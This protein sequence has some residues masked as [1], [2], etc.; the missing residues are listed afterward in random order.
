ME[1]TAVASPQS[2]HHH[3]GRDERRV[4]IRIASYHWIILEPTT[5]VIHLLLF[6]RVANSLH[7]IFRLRSTESFYLYSKT[8]YNFR[9]NG[10]WVNFWQ[11]KSQW[12]CLFSLNHDGSIGRLTSRGCRWRAYVM[13]IKY[14]STHPERVRLAKSIFKMALCCC[15]WFCLPL[16]VVLYPVWTLFHILMGNN[17]GYEIKH[18]RQGHFIIHQSTFDFVHCPL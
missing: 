17:D 18:T 2:I 6:P 10:Y 13:V 11:L 5:G 12:T 4:T 7:Q 3:H 14:G 16:P 9:W 8:F 15:F 1:S